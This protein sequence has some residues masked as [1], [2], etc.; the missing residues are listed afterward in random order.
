MTADPTDPKPPITATAPPTAPDLPVVAVTRGE[1]LAPQRSSPVWRRLR[2]L[3]FVPL[4]MVLIMAG[5]VIGLYLQP[6][7]IRFA[8]SLLGLQ[9][10][11]GTSNPIAVPPPPA[12]APLAAPKLVAGLGKLVPAGEVLTIAPP[13]GAGDARIERLLVKEGDRVAAGAVLAV[14]D[15]EKAFAAAYETA[16]ANVAARD[17]TLAQVRVSVEASRA[18]TRAALARAEATA[19]NA[20]REYERIDALRRSGT[21][22]E[23][24]ADQRRTTRDETAREVERLKATLMRYGEDLDSQADIVVARRNLDAAQ[25]D[26]ARARADLDKTVVR[27]PIAATV[28]SIAAYPGERPGTA[29]LMN[30]GDIDHMNAEIEVYQAQIGLVR[31]GARVEVTAEAL[32]QPLTGEVTRIGL[33]VGRQT[34]TDPSPAANTDARVVKVTVQLDPASSQR[35]ARFS[36]LQVLARIAAAP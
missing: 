4:V 13:F 21:V 34:V 17:A 20:A 32:G 15:N 36:N 5:G 19:Q 26:L 6:P 22:A 7:G 35:A 14:L 16:R 30:L 23:T 33:E 10:G 9:P 31:V 12:A 18:E 27:A 28:L 8:M 11:G 25:A 29:G 1:V 2:V 3:R 24:T